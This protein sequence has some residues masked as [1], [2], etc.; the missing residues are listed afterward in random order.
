MEF[1]SKHTPQRL[2][3]AGSSGLCFGLFKGIVCF[4][5]VDNKVRFSPPG[6]PQDQIM[7]RAVAALMEFRTANNRVHTVVDRPRVRWK[8]PPTEFYKVNFDGAV[9]KEEDRVGIGVII[10][11]S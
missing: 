4:H 7:Q 8:A 10:K 2:C 3:T 11:D 5:H 9:F 6:F 1:T